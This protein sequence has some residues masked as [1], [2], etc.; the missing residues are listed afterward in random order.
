MTREV[1]RGLPGFPGYHVSNRGWVTDD[2]GELVDTW[3]SGKGVLLIKL[4]KDEM[5]YRGPVWK[6]V[7]SS[8]CTGNLDGLKV[9]YIDG[10]SYNVALDNLSFWF[11]SVRFQQ[12]CTLTPTFKNDRACT[13]DRRRFVKRGTK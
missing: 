6:L 11:Y 5:S 7:M 3:D 12:N 4:K 2:H 8:F 10:D 1:W 9:D 13:L